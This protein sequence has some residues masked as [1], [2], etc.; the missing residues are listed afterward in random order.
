MFI[1]TNHAFFEKAAGAEDVAHGR[2]ICVG[3]V[4]PFLR[5]G[6]VV[7]LFIVEIT[8]GSQSRAR[9]SKFLIQGNI[10]PFGDTLSGLLTRLS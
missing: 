5:C 1:A 2:L 4:L 3:A 10:D 8:Y 9:G 7:M 6:S